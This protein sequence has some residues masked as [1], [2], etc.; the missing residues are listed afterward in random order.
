M[1]PN[2]VINQTDLLKIIEKKETKKINFNYIIIII[3]SIGCCILHNRY[4]NKKS[5][6]TD[7]IF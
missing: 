5:N 7:Y 1:K 4:K 3:L 6:N 2:L